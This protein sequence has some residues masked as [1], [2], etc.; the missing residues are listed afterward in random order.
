MIKLSQNENAFGTPPLALKAIAE[1][2]PTPHLSLDVIRPQADGMG[3]RGN[4]LLVLAGS[5]ERLR[6]RAEGPVFA[7]G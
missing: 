7:L 2:G 1:H 6:L 3:V 5:V 4:G